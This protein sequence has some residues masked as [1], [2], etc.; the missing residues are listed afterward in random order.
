MQNKIFATVLFLTSAVSCSSFK[1]TVLLEAYLNPLASTLVTYDDLD[2]QTALFNQFASGLNY[3]LTLDYSTYYANQVNFAFG[4]V[5]PSGYFPFN[6]WDSVTPTKA[7]AV[8][9]STWR[10]RINN[11]LFNRDF[12]R[13]TNKADTNYFLEF[14]KWPL[15]NV[16]LEI[17]L[18]S[19]IKY[20][21]NVGS[22]Y[23]AF[24]NT[25]GNNLN[26]IFMYISFFNGNEK[27]Q[28]VLLWS[29]DLAGTSVNYL[30]DLSTVITN[31]D[32][33]V[34]NI[35]HVDTPPFTTDYSTWRIN[36]FNLF[37]QQSQ[38][39]IPEDTDGDRFGFEFVAVE[40][41]NFLGHLQNFAWWIVNKSPVAPVFEFID[42]YIVTWIS[43]LIDFI[44]GVF[45]I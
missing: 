19:K 27:L 40:W 17:K 28:D 44:T 32:N 39:S 22:V 16:N 9:D 10:T 38:I 7:T 36:E 11:V 37:T 8:L 14:V 13:T 18:I 41:W 21:V 25:I 1:P 31:V 42:T 5:N 3:E 24:R 20:S 6:A 15:D 30:F 43:G 33:F 45:N 2:F 29:S 35:Q 4:V 34:I 12:D 26:G 23:M